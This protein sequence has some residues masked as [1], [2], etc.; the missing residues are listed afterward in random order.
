MALLSDDVINDITEYLQW[1]N[2]IDNIIKERKS[3]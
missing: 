3:Y 1:N 2:T